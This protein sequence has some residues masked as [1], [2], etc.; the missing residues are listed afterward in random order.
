[1]GCSVEFATSSGSGVTATW[2]WIPW[3][4]LETEFAR[5]VGRSRRRAAGFLELTS[6]VS[7]RASA[8]CWSAVG[9]KGIFAAWLAAVLG[10][11]GRS[12]CVLSRWPK[13]RPRSAGFTS[14]GSLPSDCAIESSPGDLGESRVSE[15]L[16]WLERLQDA[17]GRWHDRQMLLE[18]TGR[19]GEP[20][21]QRGERAEI[22]TSARRG[23]GRAVLEAWIGGNRRRCEEMS[24]K[25]HDALG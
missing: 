18:T 11:H 12:G 5:A 9:L 8:S 17:I 1:V 24:R 22:F 2:P 23:K 10:S 13:P 15:G 19:G 7:R 25:K 14:C 21:R 6:V 20:R 16:P 3:L 4:R